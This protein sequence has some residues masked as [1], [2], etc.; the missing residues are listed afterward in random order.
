MAKFFNITGPCNPEE[1]YTLPPSK[2]LVGSQLNRYVENK[3]FWVLHAARQTG[4]T[5]FL[6]SWMRELNADDK[7]VACYVSVEQ[8]QG[9]HERSIGIPAICRS[10]Q[11]Y[12][13][14][15]NLPIPPMPEIE[16]ESSLDKILSDW[17]KLV[18]PKPLI[19][20][21]DEVDVLEGDVLISF[22]RQLRGGFATRGIG[23]FP[24]SV[25]LVGMRDLKDYLVNSKNGM[26]LNSGSPFNIKQDSATLANFSK[27]DVIDLFG[28][29]TAECGRLITEEATELVFEQTGGQPW[30]V[31]AI[32]DRCLNWLNLSETETIT[33]SH[34]Q[35]AR[36]QIIKSRA[37]H[38]D[39]LAA[40]LK[41]PRVKKIIEP[42]MV[43]A[44]DPTLAESEDF[45]FCI[46]LGLVSLIDGTPSISNPIYREVLARTLSFGMQT[47][48]PAPEFKWEKADGDLDIDALIKEFQL[49]WRRHSEVWESKAD[50]TEAFPHLLLM[51][52][53]QRVVNGGARIEREYAAG[54]GRID[55]AIFWKKSTHIFEIKLVHPQ[56][57]YETTLNEGKAQIARYADKLPS[58]TR[59]LVIFDRR[60]EIKA[61]PW[62]ER[63]DI[64]KTEDASKKELLVF[65]G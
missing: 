60:P 34:I 24:V 42:I 46:D 30:L 47:A 54:R 62:D 31:N 56:D 52:F 10:I 44:I 2:R 11:K 26:V 40:R 17:A 28:Q 36:E 13:Q 5:T 15:F 18:L 45:R 39:S 27:Q 9:I 33:A 8:C 65:R 22:L 49:F 41:D 38:L 12:A 59:T 3:L 23:R 7:V 55:L 53:L 32:Y 57:G 20:L 48:I 61:K 6:Q 63:L 37:V 29:H 21:F 64:F 35:I 25:A 1:H 19:V 51:A 16:P 4:K 14:D 43:G 58:T 50:Y